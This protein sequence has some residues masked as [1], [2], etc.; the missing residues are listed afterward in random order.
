MYYE[1]LPA[2]NNF[3]HGLVV[4]L[5]ETNFNTDLAELLALKAPEL[6]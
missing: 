5:L 6:L 2:V 4:F 1:L 3:G